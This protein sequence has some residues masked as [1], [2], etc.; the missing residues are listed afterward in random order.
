MDVAVSPVGKWVLRILLG[1]FLLFLYAPMVFL[2]VVFSFNDNDL[3]IFPLQGFTTHAYEQF[4]ANPELRDAVLTSAKVAAPPAS[5]ASCSVC[6]RRWRS[7]AGGSSGSRPSRHSCS[8][9]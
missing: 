7:S 2:L 1:F 4:F 6:W 5:S 8:A 9:R 3:P